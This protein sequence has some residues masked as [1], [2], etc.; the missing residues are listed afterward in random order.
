MVFIDTDLS[1]QAVP[2]RK[3]VATCKQ[4]PS[5]RST[6]VC[7]PFGTVGFILHTWDFLWNPWALDVLKLGF[8]A[9]LP[10]TASNTSVYTNTWS[11]ATK[12]RP[13]TPPQSQHLDLSTEK[14][15][16]DRNFTQF[17]ICPETINLNTDPNW[18][19]ML[20]YCYTLSSGKRN[21][22]S[23]DFEII[24]FWL[25]CGTSFT[26]LEENVGWKVWWGQLAVPCNP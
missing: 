20:M 1:S 2:Q 17:N 6:V 5:P 13:L 15:T 4:M 10:F 12:P 14:D 24:S 9:P 26:R 18:K 3:V 16:T 7:V 8:V 21:Q 25:E 23:M 11:R 19:S 22:L